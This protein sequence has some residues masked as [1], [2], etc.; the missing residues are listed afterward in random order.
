[1]ESTAKQIVFV[2]TLLGIFVILVQDMP[3]GFYA[4]A[5]SYDVPE[6]PDYWSADEIKA[7]VN[8]TATNMTVRV[9]V[10]EIEVSGVVETI[11]IRAQWWNDAFK[12]WH[13]KWDI[14]GSQGEID[15]H[16][17]T[18]TAVLANVDDTGNVSLTIMTCDHHNYY[19]YIVNPGNYSS[20]TTC[21]AADDVVTVDIG[22]MYDY[23][24]SVLSGS[25]ILTRL[26]LFQLPNVTPEINFLIALP[27]YTLVGVL[28]FIVITMV[29]DMFPL[30]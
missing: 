21:L 5:P 17:L 6:Y 22:V 13:W 9:Q 7:M 20:L 30:T 15:P 4:V 10:Y 19:V 29:V 8:A 11:Y 2:V 25:D 27:V 14:W 23:E 18:E 28:A 16:P 1:M 24:Q 12:F 26:L 3:S